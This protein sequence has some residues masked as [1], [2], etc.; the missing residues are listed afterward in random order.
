M[1]INSL[2]QKEAVIALLNCCHCT[3]WAQLM[4]ELLPFDNKKTFYDN[5]KTIWLLLT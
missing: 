2:T 3:T 1:K 5:A 4:V